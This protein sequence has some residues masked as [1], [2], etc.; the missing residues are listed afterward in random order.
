MTLTKKIIKEFDEKFPCSQ[1]DCD[2]NGTYPTPSENGCDPNQCRVCYEERLPIKSFILSS[3]HQ[4]ATEA[5]EA[6]KLEK[7]NA[8]NSKYKFD[9][10]FALDQI[11]QKAKK[12]LE[13][14]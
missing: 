1:K 3:L 9:Y 4:V 12:F 6:V 11:E 7:V 10:N 2:N 14:L 5:I 13:N 8:E